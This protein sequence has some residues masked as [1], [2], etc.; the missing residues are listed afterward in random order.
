MKKLT[1]KYAGWALLYMG[2]PFTAVGNWFWKKHK[3][4]LDMNDCCCSGKE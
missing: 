1:I 4:V 3:Q 2:K